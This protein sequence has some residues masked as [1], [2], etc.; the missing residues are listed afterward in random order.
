MLPPSAIETLCYGLDIVDE[1]RCPSIQ[2]PLNW[3]RY[4]RKLTPFPLTLIDIAARDALGHSGFLI[5]KP[6]RCNGR[7]NQQ[8][9]S[10]EQDFKN[11]LEFKRRSD[12][13]L[14]FAQRLNFRLSPLQRHGHFID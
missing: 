1:N 5:D 3:Q 14:D 4:S 13:L 10:P 7:G 12:G 9:D 6:N 11:A 2:N 8:G